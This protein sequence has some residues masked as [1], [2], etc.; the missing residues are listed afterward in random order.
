MVELHNG[1]TVDIMQET[2]GAAAAALVP[3]GGETAVTTDQSGYLYV[4]HPV[5]KRV[6]R[7]QATEFAQKEQLDDRKQK[8][9][10]KRANTGTPIMEKIDSL[11]ATIFTFLKGIL[12]GMATLLLV[13]LFHCDSK[14]GCTRSHAQSG[15]QLTRAPSAGFL[16][17]TLFT[18]RRQVSPDAPCVD[19]YLCVGYS[20][21]HVA[22]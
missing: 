14:V 1:G 18:E 13:S 5:T 9:L 10:L 19:V 21:A 12:A 7:K 4:Q 6:T 2:S 20:G 3:G 17:I 15:V 16:N 11:L 22:R 8:E